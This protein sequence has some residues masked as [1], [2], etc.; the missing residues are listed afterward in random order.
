[1]FRLGHR[2]EFG[3]CDTHATLL[4]IRIREHS[5]KGVTVKSMVDSFTEYPA[6]LTVDN[7]NAAMASKD[8]FLDVL[9]HRFYGLLGSHSM[10][11]KL[12]AD[13]RTSFDAFIDGVPWQLFR[14]PG[15]DLGFDKVEGY[16]HTQ[17][18][19]LYLNTVIFLLA[20]DLRHRL[21]SANANVIPR[22]KGNHP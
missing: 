10:N 9:I 4:R 12:V 21:E 6:A 13:P 7:S 20:N 14:F 5:D 15:F 17:R 8:R 19:R 16:L 1:M 2:S 11:P 22:F 18:P 3:D